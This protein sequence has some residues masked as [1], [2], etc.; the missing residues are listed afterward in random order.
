MPLR[1]STIH[2]IPSSIPQVP[3]L[4]QASS[5][6]VQVLVC[7]HADPSDAYAARCASQMATLRAKYPQQFWAQ[8]DRYFEQARAEHAEEECRSGRTRRRLAA[9]CEPPSTEALDGNRA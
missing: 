3:A 7:G 8:P 6:R 5:G 1:P 4:L 2:S 9:A